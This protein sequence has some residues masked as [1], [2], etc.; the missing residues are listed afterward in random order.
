M[1]KIG[2]VA[3]LLGVDRS[4]LHY[5]DEIG[6]IVPN[7]NEKK[8][9][10][11]N[12]NDLIAIAS[13]KYYRA[14]NMPL[15]DLSQV[16]LE[17]NL[18]NKIEIMERQRT[19]LLQEAERMKDLAEVASYALETYR[20]AYQEAILDQAISTGFD[21]VPMIQNGSYDPNQIQQPAIQK[22]L[23][24]FPFVSYAYY[25]PAGS[26]IDPARFRYSLGLST[27]Q[28]FRIKYQIELPQNTISKSDQACMILPI[29]KNIENDSF[30]F[31]DFHRIRETAAKKKIELTGEAIAY[32]VFT[33]Y[34]HDHAKIK[35][36]VQIITK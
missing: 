25:F 7:K 16:I 18:Q 19:L 17:S 27:I 4:F 5:Y 1:F 8:Y 15:K 21:F 3:K 23:Q 34:E 33:N 26:L 9:R 20:I 32:C 6:I 24:F 30:I 29:T 14:M 35:F 10:L 36:V 31:E 12:E 2:E 22:L 11:Y 28:H 13:S